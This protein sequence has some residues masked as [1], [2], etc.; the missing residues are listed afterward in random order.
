MTS[1]NRKLVKENDKDKKDKKTL[2]DVMSKIDGVIKKYEPILFVITLICTAILDCVYIYILP[3]G[4]RKNIV[5]FYLTALFLLSLQLLCSKIFK[6]IKFIPNFGDSTWLSYIT[7]V[8]ILVPIIVIAIHGYIVQW[9]AEMDI[10]C[11]CRLYIG[12][13]QAQILSGFCFI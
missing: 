4:I 13:L 7:F 2:K 6:R 3:K 5:I 11:L 1:R 10:A 9:D 12:A 8:I